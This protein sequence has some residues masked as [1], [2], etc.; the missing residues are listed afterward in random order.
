MK[1]I[2]LRITSVSYVSIYVCIKNGHNENERHESIRLT[3][4]EEHLQIYDGGRILPYFREKLHNVQHS[5]QYC[6]G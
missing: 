4:P 6:S 3:E 2:V 5:R 1:N